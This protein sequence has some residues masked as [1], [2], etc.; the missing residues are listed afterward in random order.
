MQHTIIH[1]LLK[2][3]FVATLLYKNVT[4]LEKCYYVSLGKYCFI[5]SNSL[6]KL[7]FPMLSNIGKMLFYV[8]QFEP[9]LAIVTIRV[10]GGGC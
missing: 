2:C 4:T 5:I 8:S 3:F 1:S 9:Q 7:Y 10:L 6:E